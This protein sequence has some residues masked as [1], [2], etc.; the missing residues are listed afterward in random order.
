[1]R[2]E[3]GE[4][5]PVKVNKKLRMLKMCCFCILVLGITCLYLVYSNEGH[6]V[7]KGSGYV[8]PK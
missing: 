7:E 8:E 4:L 1:M 3:G 2:F 6:R 5:G